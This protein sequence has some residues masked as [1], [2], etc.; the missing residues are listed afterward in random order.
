MEIHTPELL[1]FHDGQLVDD[2]FPHNRALSRELL[3]S[4]AELT[5]LHIVLQ[6][7]DAGLG[8]IKAGVGDFVEE[9]DVLEANDAQPRVPLL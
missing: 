7:A 3:V 6:D 1:G 2:P 9:H 8:I 5:G 4:P